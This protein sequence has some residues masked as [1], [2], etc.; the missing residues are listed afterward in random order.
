MERPSPFYPVVAI[1]ALILALS[2]LAQAQYGGGTGEPNDPY[3]ITT[4]EQMN[5]IGADPNNWDKHFKLMADIDLS[6]YSGTEFNLIGA[7]T[8][9][10]WM[11]D[12]GDSEPFV[13]VFDG[14]GHSISNF[15]YTCNGETVVGLF[16]HVDGPDAEIRDLALV[17]PNIDA[18]GGE[19]VGS[20]VGYSEEGVI[21][22]CYVEG[23][24]VSGRSSVGGLVG[25]VRSGRDYYHGAVVVGCG[26]T[27]DVVGVFYVGGLVGSS[28]GFITDCCAS[29]IVT[30]DDWVGGLVGSGGSLTGCC[31][32]AVVMGKNCV[33]GLTGFGGV[34]ESCY[35]QG[36][37]MGEEDVGGLAGDASGIRNCYAQGVAMGENDVGGLAGSAE[38][39]TN[40]YATT[41]VLADWRGGGLVADADQD[42][43]VA[44]FW[45]VQ[46]SLQA[47][48]AGGEGKTT[49]QMQR[50][51]TFLYWGKVD[52]GGTWTIDEGNDYPRLACEN[53]PGTVIGPGPVSDLLKG[54]G[55]Q[56]DPYLIY[57][58]DEMEVI[59]DDPDEWG[60]HFKL[61]ADIDLGGRPGVDFSM[62]FYQY[63]YPFTGSFDGN[64]R[65]ISNFA[66]VYEEYAGGG[67]FGSV[68][69]VDC[70]IRDSEDDCDGVVSPVIENLR[71]LN[72]VIDSRWVGT[73]GALVA[74]LEDGTVRN[75]RVEG[76]FV[77]GGTKGAG[78][79]VGYSR[80]TV[81]RCYVIGGTVVG[82]STAGGL[83]G[84]NYGDIAN[85]YSENTVLGTEEAEDWWAPWEGVGGLVGCNTG[86]VTNCYSASAVAGKA[87]VGG[88]VGY[89]SGQVVASFWDVETSG[90]KTS[91]GGIGLTTAEMQ[92]AAPFLEAGWD[93]ID[94]VENGQEDIWYMPEG[95]YPRLVWES[96]D[97][98]F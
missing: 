44:S 66:C 54:T 24:T 26:S 87:T 43:I 52:N 90:Q 42:D 89:D 23:G 34:I 65:T 40:C 10:F 31:A 96:V 46:T 93:F 30:G 85:C 55:T 76:A 38:S 39:I 11:R 14:N 41:A 19:R 69:S 75:C 49:A 58:A 1:C 37:V 15:T 22:N 28:G 79:L 91:A 47:T 98:E 70:R 74:D 8:T 94:E 25:T 4:A 50:L 3:L 86:S 33:G 48:S 80:G 13:G 97:A 53:R 6:A 67:F 68:E 82:G 12:P 71:L 16:R 92:A 78:G 59:A 83:I 57:T 32:D 2:T 88:L 35:A 61:M 36:V 95:D 72:P 81:T 84:R 51:A 64:G 29:G 20:L 5:A 62:S 56:D 21:R 9:A 60:K 63:S 45:D 7:E 17:N 18:E 27:C 73:A 77:V